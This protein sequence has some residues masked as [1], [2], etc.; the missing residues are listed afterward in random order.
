ML[1]TALHALLMLLMR[2][3][4]LLL[5]GRQLRRYALLL[6]AATRCPLSIDAAADAT[7]YAEDAT[8]C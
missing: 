2:A 5:A 6:A 4:L 3:M 8:P 7:R 1:Y